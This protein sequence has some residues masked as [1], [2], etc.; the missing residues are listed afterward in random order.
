MELY[1]F[2][3]VLGLVWCVVGVFSIVRDWTGEFDVEYRDICKLF[4]AGVT[5]GP[6]I[7]LKILTKFV[8]VIIF[9]SFSYSNVLIKKRRR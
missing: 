5:I 2:G 4:F 9:P 8:L 1:I 3:I 6:L 7:G